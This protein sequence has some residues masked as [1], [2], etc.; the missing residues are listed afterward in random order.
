MFIFSI[1][2]RMRILILL[3]WL[4]FFQYEFI[5]YAQSQDSLSKVY[6][7]DFQDSTAAAWQPNHPESWL[8]NTEA[9]GQNIY[10]LTAPGTDTDIRKPTSFSILSSFDVETFEMTVYGKCFTDN[11]VQGRDL[12]LFFGYQDSLHFYYVHFSN[13]S[14]DVHNIIGIVNNEDRKKINLEP[15][16]TSTARLTDKDWHHLKIYRNIETG[17]IKAYIDNLDKPILTAVDTTFKCGKIGLGSFDDTGAFKSFRLW[18]IDSSQTQVNGTSIKS[19]RR[20]RLYPNFPNPFN[21]STKIEFYI[22]ERQLVDLNVYDI[23]GRKVA[24]LVFGKMNSGRHRVCWD[25]SN[26]ST[27]IYFL[28]L[29]AG[30]SRL[31]S[32]LTL[33][34]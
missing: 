9:G 2:R 25:A 21:L 19:C 20:H 13:A 23:N 7:D 31:M 4:S 11:G 12:C 16:G 30:D 29:S 10:Q 18:G 34:K 32:R 28:Q 15:P 26:V 8:V 1:S 3:V 17:E 22:P 6:F 5:V 14:G 24:S 33:I 27:G